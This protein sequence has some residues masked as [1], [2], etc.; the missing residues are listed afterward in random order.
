M[1]FRYLWV[2]PFPPEEIQKIL[3]DELSDVCLGHLKKRGWLQWPGNWHRWVIGVK[4]EKPPESGPKRTMPDL[5]LKLREKKTR[6]IYCRLRNKI[7]KAL[8]G[9][10]ERTNGNPRVR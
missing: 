4:F 9:L 2:N 5:L 8:C 3:P 1:V 6:S 10:L 7:G